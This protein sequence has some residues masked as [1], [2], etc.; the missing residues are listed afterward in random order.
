MSEASIKKQAGYV[1]VEEFSKAGL[2]YFC[3]TCTKYQPLRETQGYCQ[4][5]QVRVR[6][7]GCC[8]Y[9]ELNDETPMTAS[10]ISL[11]VL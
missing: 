5:L 4:G 11:T 9:W 2:G 1:Q 7:Y 10:G 3:G 8:N 6:S